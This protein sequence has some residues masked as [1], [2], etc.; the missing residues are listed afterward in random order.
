MKIGFKIHS[1]YEN[2]KYWFLM[3]T[4]SIGIGHCTGFLHIT[5]YFLVWELGIEFLWKE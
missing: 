4:P 1:H 5:L 3:I 2:H